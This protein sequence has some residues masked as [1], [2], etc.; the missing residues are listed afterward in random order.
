M[1][2]K[3][4]TYTGENIDVMYDIPRC[5]HAAE[6]IR[7]LNAVFDTEKRPWI[8]PDNAEADQLAAVILRCPTGALHFQR[9]DGGSEEPTPDDNTIQL[10]ENGPL[11][12]RGDVTI[13][14]EDAE[15]LLEDTRLALCRCGHSSN[16]PLCDNS[17]V[18][19]AFHAAAD[20]AADDKTQPAVSGGKLNI[21]PAKNGPLLL[22]GNFTLLN[23][24]GEN[25][26]AGKKAALCRCGG[27][28]NKPF[29]DGTHRKINFEAS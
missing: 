4:K 15:V 2:H 12:V 18:E 29:C 24:A 23:G 1:K 27:S 26:Y 13:I 8:Q 16:K 6:C 17:H 11:F 28:S 9:K 22:Q 25:I 20:Y 14:A 7:G 3:I 21:N 10:V 5:I 19:A